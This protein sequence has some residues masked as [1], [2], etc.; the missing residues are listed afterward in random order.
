MGGGKQSNNSTPRPQASATPL[1]LGCP[2]QQRPGYS[3]PGSDL[4][5]LRRQLH[6]LGCKLRRQGRQL[7][8]L[9]RDLAGNAT[10]L[11]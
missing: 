7:P 6:L 8:L 1:L 4:I 9:E 2:G 11:A 10:C 3:R 5:L